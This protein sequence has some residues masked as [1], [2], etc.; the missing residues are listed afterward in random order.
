MNKLTRTLFRSFLRYNRRPEVTKNILVYPAL[1][2]PVLQNLLPNS[3]T[4][5]KINSSETL[6]AAIYH[7]FRSDK[8]NKDNLN[9]YIDLG[10]KTLKILNDELPTLRKQLQDKEHHINNINKATYKIGQVVYLKDLKIRGIVCGWKIDNDEQLVDIMLDQND[11]IELK[12]TSSFKELIKKKNDKSQSIYDNLY[13]YYSKDNYST[14]SDKTNNK[15]SSEYYRNM[16]SLI[17]PNVSENLLELITNNKKELSFIH[18]KKF[19]QYF[20]VYNKEI[21]RYLPMINI[22]INYPL[23][24]TE[25]EYEILKNSFD[26]YGQLRTVQDNIIG[27]GKESKDIICSKFPFLLQNYNDS[28]SPEEILSKKELELKENGIVYQ[29]LNEFI[30][31][32]YNLTDDKY[33]NDNK[34]LDSQN[35]NN[36]K[37]Q[38]LRG[39]NNKNLY[40]CRNDPQNKFIFDILNNTNKLKD[41]SFI[42]SFIQLNDYLQFLLNTRFQAIGFE[43]LHKLNVKEI[44]TDK[45]DQNGEFIKENIFSLSD[46]KIKDWSEFLNP[47]EDDIKARNYNN[48]ISQDEKS[49]SPSIHDPNKFSFHSGQVVKHK[50]FGFHG[51]IYSANLRPNSDTSDW[52][53]VLNS[54]IG[55]EQPFYRILPDKEE[56]YKVF[57]HYSPYDTIYVPQDSLESVNN[58][59]KYNINNDQIN[60][61][62]QRWDFV[63]KKYIPFPNFTYLFPTNLYSFPQ[64]FP[65][66][67][68]FKK[69]ENQVNNEKFN[70]T[71]E[72]KSKFLKELKTFEDIDSVI[73]QLNSLI[74]GVFN[75]ARVDYDA[76]QLA[77][78]S[79]SSSSC[80]STSS[81]P[82]K[83]SLNVNH[84]LELLKNAPNSKIAQPFDQLLSS[85]F[86]SH[87]DKDIQS[88]LYIGFNHILRKNFSSAI[89]CYEK[90]IELDP[91]FSE[92]YIKLSTIQLYKE[93]YHFKN[94]LKNIPQK[95]TENN[96]DIDS[97]D[98]ENQVSDLDFEVDPSSL[99]NSLA[100]AKKAIVLSPHY[101]NA[102]TNLFLVLDASNN[103]ESSVNILRD[104]LH[105]HPWINQLGTIFHSIQLEDKK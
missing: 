6:Q 59:K 29:V 39:G 34:N 105:L 51:V 44:I 20:I 15:S 32:L 26:F 101:I 23:D 24:Y 81:S 89:K 43:N 66:N 103:K 10:F 104:V 65:E 22:L 78:S 74:S 100:N 4:P 36:F 86:S 94:K 7:C 14:S 76:S 16:S 38:I 47:S 57:G 82:S 95:S 40:T 96:D 41:L 79:T 5:D 46:S 35:N 3:I 80:Y 49:S 102:L 31:L 60:L 75:K 85:I 27:I 90:I 19:F 11:V 33:I 61:Y 8:I 63:T 53:D 13:D 72:E 91:N 68:A 77:S 45:K 30:P 17:L 69:F 9:S 52:E 56:Y 67:T 25:N 12:D 71:D 83:Y 58:F 50:K 18:N 1:K 98:E 21:D 73:L 2:D 37:Q 42:Q 88:L 84:L 48:E 93:K 62:F 64:S 87:S 99:Q 55:Q 97:K 54:P 92:P 28:Y 70:L